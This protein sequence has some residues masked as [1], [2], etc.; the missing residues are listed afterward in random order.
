MAYPV[1]Y[2]QSDDGYFIHM[3]LDFASANNGR[4]AYFGGDC[5]AIYTGATYGL[6]DWETVEEA[7]ITVT[8]PMTLVPHPAPTIQSPEA[9]AA[10]RIELPP[11][12]VGT[13]T[14]RV[15]ARGRAL[16]RSDV[17]VRLQFWPATDKAGLSILAIGDTFDPRTLTSVTPRPHSRATA[18]T[19][20]PD[21][22]ESTPRNSGTVEVSHHL[23]LI[24][25][26]D[27]DPTATYSHGSVFDAGNNL[28]SVHTGIAS[29][30]V[31]VTVERFDGDPLLESGTLP[32][33]DSAWESI[34]E[35][36]VP[37]QV[38]MC[39][40]TLNGEIIDSLGAFVAP[41]SGAR[42]FRVCARGR[43][44]NWDMIVDEPTERYLVQTWPS[45]GP[46][47]VVSKKWTDG[48]WEA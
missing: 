22:P 4:L 25:G 34:D 13:Y 30:P 42:S 44:S 15:S 3:Q 47:M 31:E 40:I 29:G 5:A 38:D 35:V 28:I 2:L 37:S 12:E 41:P 14:L 43:A 9:L 18:S 10:T 1:L 20:R 33:D 7:T 46:S 26:T 8:S 39:F 36:T 21:A 45:D 32:T 6:T 24:S 16:T 48:V 17:A 19:T 27:I 23:F 11:L